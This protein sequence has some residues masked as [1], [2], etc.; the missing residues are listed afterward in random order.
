MG[1][2]KW[3]P[4]TV[5]F[6]NSA[7]LAQ[8]NSLLLRH[9]PYICSGGNPLKQISGRP[10]VCA[11]TGDGKFHIASWNAQTEWVSWILPNRDRR[12][13]ISGLLTHYSRI[14]LCL[15]LDGLVWK[16]ENSNSFT[17]GNPYYSRRG[18]CTHVW[19]SVVSLIAN[20][21]R[22][23]SVLGEI[24]PAVWLFACLDSLRHFCFSVPMLCVLNK[25][26]LTLNLSHKTGC[27]G[28]DSIHCASHI[29]RFLSATCHLQCK[30][31]EKYEIII[32]YIIYVH[33]PVK[34]SIQIQTA[35]TQ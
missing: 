20:A 35:T 31:Q 21:G 34:H 16:H 33:E 10:R 1:N 4:T 13:L 26:R 19:T 9:A 17:C 6:S 18:M 5:T 22:T 32:S 12:I 23:I 15:K 14:P 27:H 11:G 25:A 24:A 2:D 28:I 7:L 8:W 29:S 30:H 3:N